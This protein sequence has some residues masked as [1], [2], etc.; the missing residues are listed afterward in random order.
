MD[1]TRNVRKKTNKS[2]NKYK[3]SSKIKNFSIIIL[4]AFYEGTFFYGRYVAASPLGD[5]NGRKWSEVDDE[6]GR[7]MT[8]Q[9]DGIREGECGRTG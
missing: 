9:G 7:R 2:R 3:K 1:C 4:E 6:S 5:G 8:R